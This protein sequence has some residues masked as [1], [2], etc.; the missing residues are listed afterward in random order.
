MNKDDF[1]LL[2]MALGHHLTEQEVNA[3]LSDIGVDV[4]NNSNNTISFD[5]FFEWWTD[6]MGV[7]AIR[8]KYYKK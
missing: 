7:E 1:E 6:S 8:K 5:L 3:C 4:T 2:L